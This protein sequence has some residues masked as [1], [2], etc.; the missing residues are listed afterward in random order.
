MNHSFD[1][2]R[3]PVD[4]A[5]RSRHR[6]RSRIGASRARSARLRAT[7][8]GGRAVRLGLGAPPAV[9]RDLRRSAGRARRRR[10]GGRD[11]RAGVV[12][13]RRRRRDQ[14]SR[15]KCC[16]GACHRDVV[17]ERRSPRGTRRV[18]PARVPERQDGPDPGRSGGGSHPR[19]HRIAA[20]RRRASTPRGALAP[21]RRAG[22]RHDD[23]A[24][25]GRSEHRLHRRRHRRVRRPRRTDHDHAPARRARRFAGDRSTSRA[26]CAK[27][28]AS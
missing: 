7:A 20:R 9:P 2:D 8:A 21:H 27:A 19:A 11:A 10:H 15:W 16:G 24:R 14:L 23:T 4:S 1:T 6:G 28:I 5:R 25:A 3:G 26:R 22:R 13:G 17:C 12:H 18:H